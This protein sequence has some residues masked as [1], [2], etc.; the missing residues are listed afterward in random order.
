MGYLKQIF[1]CLL[2]SAFGLVLSCGGGPGERIKQIAAVTPTPAPPPTE[3]EI[4]G[5]FNVTGAGENGNDPYTGMLN[6]APEGDAYSFRWNT[7]HG[8]R[9]G[10]GVQLGDATAASYANPGSGSGC[11]VVL[12]KIASD[13]SLNGRIVKWGEYKYGTEKATRIEGTGFV[14]K[15]TVTGTAPDGKQYSGTLKIAKDGGGYDFDWQTGK[16][17]VGFGTWKGSVAVVSFG[18]HKCSF[19]LFDVKSN[20]NMEGFWGGQKA[21]TFGTELAKRQ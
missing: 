1:F 7:T 8:A 4:S 12:Y 3:R 19:A 17:Q 20:G 11:G 13:G 10:V 15:Y 2:L 6:V 21:V 16:A 18:G 14:G 9:N 5:V